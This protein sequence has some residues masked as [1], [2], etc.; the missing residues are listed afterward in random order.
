MKI[1]PT[2]LIVVWE[3]WEGI[4]F[5]LASPGRMDHDWVMENAKSEPSDRIIKGLKSYQ[6]VS[7][8]RCCG[9][10]AVVETNVDRMCITV[11]P[12]TSKFRWSREVLK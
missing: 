12:V 8:V 5:F 11:T 1:V 4:P 2:V 9:N 6:E 3:C 10:L 7:C